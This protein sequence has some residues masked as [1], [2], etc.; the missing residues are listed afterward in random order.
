MPSLNLDELQFNHVIF[1]IVYRWEWN[2]PE[3]PAFLVP[4]SSTLVRNEHPFLDCKSRLPGNSLLNQSIYNNPALKQKSQGV[5]L[6][7]MKSEPKFPVETP[8]QIAC[9]WNTINLCIWNLYLS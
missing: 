6:K 5:S 7:L 9:K 3:C 2:E 8:F 1:F 4:G